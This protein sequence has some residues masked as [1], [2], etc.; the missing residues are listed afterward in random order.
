MCEE[1]RT[2][3]ARKADEERAEQIAKQQFT[4]RLSII[5]QLITVVSMIVTATWLV[6]KIDNKTELNAQANKTTKELVNVVREEMKS[7]GSK[8]DKTNNELNLIKG[9]LNPI[10]VANQKQ[11]N[12]KEF[13]EAILAA[14]SG[15]PTQQ[16]TVGK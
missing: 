15:V 14:R 2:F 16:V 8:L 1:T 3:M 13:V 7:I 4:I 10:T 9:G 5:C 12:V 11:A 6:S